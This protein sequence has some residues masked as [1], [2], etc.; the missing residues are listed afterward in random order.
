MHFLQNIGLKLSH[1]HGTYKERRKI[2]VSNH[3]ITWNPLISPLKDDIQSLVVMIIMHYWHYSNF[4]ISL[5]LLA[6]R[7]NAG[8]KWHSPLWKQNLDSAPLVDIS[9]E[10][11]E[12]ERMHD[13]GLNYVLYNVISELWPC[14]GT[15]VSSLNATSVWINLRSGWRIKTRMRSGSS[16]PWGWSPARTSI[17]VGST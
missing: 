10:R 1:D 6:N 12:E 3:K 16:A 9:T 4:L 5:C 2:R 15:V 11:W 13:I 7:A 8:C 14:L 17:S